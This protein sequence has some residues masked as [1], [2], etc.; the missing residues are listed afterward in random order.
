MD[1]GGMSPGTQ[2][3]RLMDNLGFPDKLGDMYGMALDKAIGNDLGVARNMFDLFSPLKTSQLD[4]MM[5]GG[6]AGPGFCPR[7][8]DNFGHHWGVGRHTHYDRESISV[9]KEPGLRGALGHNDVMIDGKKVDVGKDKGI[10]PQNLEKKILTD[11]AFRA[12]IEG[13]VGGRIVLD[14]N[15]DG[16]ITIAK[17]AHHPMIPFHNQV[18][19]HVGNMLGRLVGGLGQGIGQGIGGMLGGPMGGVMNQMANF[20]GGGFGGGVQGPGGQ[21]GQAGGPGSP[22]ADT[23]ELQSILSNPNLSFESKLA[24][25]MGKFIEKKQK[26]MEAKMNEMTKAQDQS[27]A[28][29]KA[30]GGGGGKGGGKG[31]GGGKGLGGLLQ[32]GGGLVGGMFGGPIGSALGSSLGGAVG[33]ALGGGGGAGQAGGQGGAGQAGG[34]QSGSEQKLQT[35]LTAI[36]Q[37]FNRMVEAMNNVMKSVHDMGMSSARLIR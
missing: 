15:P 12:K 3:N 25:F 7:P 10:T 4:R 37:A 34:S 13:Q 14:G 36:T 22:S 28:G 33:G 18:H 27:K 11:P 29:D 1:V 5:G 17:Q 6:F 32:M 20:L 35:E 8:H 9:F 2:L 26:E 19:Q 31:G 24:L 16:N 21:A 30:G 23:K